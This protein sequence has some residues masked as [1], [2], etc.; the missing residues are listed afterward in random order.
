MK[1]SQIIEELKKDKNI[2]LEKIV[3]IFNENSI[4]KNVALHL[5]RIHFNY[6]YSEIMACLDSIY[7]DVPINPFNKDF[8]DNIDS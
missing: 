8:I 7:K 2:S 6:K 1:N 4:Q 5:I 3:N